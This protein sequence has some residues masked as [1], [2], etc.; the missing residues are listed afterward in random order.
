MGFIFEKK[1]QETIKKSTSTVFFLLQIAALDKTL[2]Y[3]QL[4]PK[5][6][7]Q[8]DK[9]LFNQL[10][11]SLERFERI[12][13]RWT[14][15]LMLMLHRCEG[16][17]EYFTLD[18]QTT[19]AFLI[20]KTTSLLA[21][22]P[23]TATDCEIADLLSREFEGCYFIAQTPNGNWNSLTE[24]FRDFFAYYPDADVYIGDQPHAPAAQFKLK[25]M[26]LIQPDYTEY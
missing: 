3:D 8:M 25:M 7:K 22:L 2:Q 18:E 24:S 5:T 20:N 4:Q 9:S 26:R 13:P 17:M 23:A 15:I 6:D 19:E 21:Q 1:C 16:F 11:L 14:G 12:S 10:C